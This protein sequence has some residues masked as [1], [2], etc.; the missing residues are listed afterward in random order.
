M[1]KVY[2]SGSGNGGIAQLLARTQSP[3]IWKNASALAEGS[4][5]SAWLLLGS[6][7]LD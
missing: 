7:I 2:S 4:V 6:L 1:C 5:A 3:E